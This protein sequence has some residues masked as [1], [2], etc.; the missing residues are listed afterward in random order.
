MILF[1]VLSVPAFVVQLV[2]LFRWLKARKNKTGEDL[3]ICVMGFLVGQAYL[4]VEVLAVKVTGKPVAGSPEQQMLMLRLGLGGFLGGLF[5]VFGLFYGSF[6]FF[7]WLKSR[8][9]QKSD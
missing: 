4:L 5:T 1:F 3:K 2:L 7:G 8:A 9:N 6:A